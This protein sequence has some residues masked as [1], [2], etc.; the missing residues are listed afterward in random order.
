MTTIVT[1]NCLGT[2][3]KKRERR[4]REKRE[5]ERGGKIGGQISDS[6]DFNFENINEDA[7]RQL[8]FE[9]LDDAEKF[10]TLYADVVGFGIR[11]Q[12]VK[13]KTADDIIKYREWVCAC[14]GFRRRPKADYTRKREAKVVTRCG[15]IACFRVAHDRFSGHYSVTKFE[16]Q[17]NHDLRGYKKRYISMPDKCMLNLITDAGFRPCQAMDLLEQLAGGVGK[18]SFTRKDGYNWL[19]SM[20]LKRIEGGDV[21]TIVSF[22]YKYTVNDQGALSKLFWCDGA[23]RAE[24]EIFGDVLIFDSTYKTNKYFYPLVIFSGTNNHGS[25]F[26]F[27]A[28][29][30][31]NETIES[32]RWLLQAFLEAMNGKVPGSVLTDQDSSMVAAISSEFPGAKHRLC[33]WHLGRNVRQNIEVADFCSDFMRLLKEPCSIDEFEISWLNMVEMYE[34]AEK[35]WVI[36]MYKKKEMWAE[37]YFRGHFMAMAC[38][39]QRAESMN[40]LIK[41]AV[42]QMMSFAEFVNQFERKIQGLRSSFLSQQNDLEKFKP[43]VRESPLQGLEKH[44]ASICTKQIF[45]M[46]RE[47]IEAEQ[48]LLVENHIKISEEHCKFIFKNYNKSDDA[49]YYVII[50]KFNSIFACSCLK[51][52]SEGVPCRHIISSF[53]FMGMTEFPEKSIH[54]RWLLD[55][56]RILKSKFPEATPVV[57]RQ[58]TR[59][60]H[61]N[62]EFLHLSYLSSHTESKFVECLTQVRKFSNEAAEEFSKHDVNIDSMSFENVDDPPVCTKSSNVNDP[63]RIKTRGASRAKQQKCSFCRYV[64]TLNWF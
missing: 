4:E 47:E 31:Y 60:A 62:K 46:I 20:R 54:T 37:A 30:M 40:S 50:D 19:N 29:F 58:Q 53:K 43:A 61:L 32:Y 33:S 23:S 56:G 39:T 55:T 59:F 28:S 25:T 52:E 5:D 13:R 41:L 38:T 2:T 15:C 9:S 6:V 42:T 21:N 8:V 12:G 10:Y 35:Q 34:V 49:R 45:Y 48:G 64:C 11:K 17:H 36:D 3:L 16:R 24:Y 27:G 22:F 44:A 1:P 7:V 18:M 51:L 26:I 63:K 57:G 14:E